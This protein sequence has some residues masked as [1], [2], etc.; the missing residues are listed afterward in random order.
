MNIAFSLYSNALAETESNEAPTLRL[1]NHGTAPSAPLP[2]TA[3]LLGGSTKQKH[4]LHSP[5]AK[6]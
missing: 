4:V 1:R 3:L 5:K 6:L 2:G